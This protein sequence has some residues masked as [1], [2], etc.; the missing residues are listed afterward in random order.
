[1]CGQK[2]AVKRQEKYEK[3]NAKCE[4]MPSVNKMFDY[5]F[6]IYTVLSRIFKNKL[7]YSL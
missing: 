3:A 2:S 5:L 1:M 7:K 6:K 4:M